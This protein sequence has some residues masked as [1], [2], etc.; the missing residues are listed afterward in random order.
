MKMAR[1]SALR[2]GRLY[3]Q[4]TFLVLISVR[5]CGSVTGTENNSVNVTLLKRAIN[6]QYAGSSLFLTIIICHFKVLFHHACWQLVGWAK[7]KTTNRNTFG[8][9]KHL[10]DKIIILY[11]H[12]FV[13]HTD[14]ES[15][16]QNEKS[17]NAVRASRAVCC[18]N[19]SEHTNTMWARNSEILVLNL[20]ATYSMH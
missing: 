1:V 16:H 9:N 8:R 12:P 15:F 7:L 17:M 2:T 18:T 5:G 20:A 14:T 11:K 6:L 19:Y 4:E 3:S 13:P 10:P